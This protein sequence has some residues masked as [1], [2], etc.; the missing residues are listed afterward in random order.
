[1]QGRGSR[2]LR[3]LAGITVVLLV[4]LCATLGILTAGMRRSVWLRTDFFMVS[5]VPPGTPIARAIPE[6]KDVIYM[7][8]R[9]LEQTYPCIAGSNGLDMG[10]VQMNAWDCT[11]NARR[12]R[13][14][15]PSPSAQPLPQNVP[16]DR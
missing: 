3:W 11:A 7:E 9:V 15:A 5:V 6:G 8:L 2:I 16:P 4:L 1:M 10:A 12:V 14:P 13:Q